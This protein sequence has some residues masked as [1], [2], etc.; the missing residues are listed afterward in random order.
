[1]P[2]RFDAFDPRVRA[3]A[4]KKMV[5]LVVGRQVILPT[6]WGVLPPRLGKPVLYLKDR[7]HGPL[8]VRSAATALDGMRGDAP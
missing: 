4:I 8:V 6:L 2:D 1:M 7:Q 3:Q 5:E